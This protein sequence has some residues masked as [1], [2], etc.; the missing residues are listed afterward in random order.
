M[1]LTISPFCKEVY[2]SA[3]YIG[4][5]VDFLSSTSWLSNGH[6]D[7]LYDAECG[8][9]LKCF[10]I[11]TLIEH[12]LHIEP[13]GD[14]HPPGDMKN[15]SMHFSLKAPMGEAVER[16][17]QDFNNGL[18]NISILIASLCED[19]LLSPFIGDYFVENA[20]P[21]YQPILKFTHKLFSH[22]VCFFAAIS[23]EYILIH[24]YFA[25]QYGPVRGILKFGSRSF[26]VDCVPYRYRR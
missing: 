7:E 2:E 22:K 12:G 14:F 25:F 10:V 5:T 6:I 23:S 15:A 13:H 18:T 21:V 20:Q 8:A 19:S 17:K 1:A 26:D 16:Y 11:G 4:K 24:G 3:G 9:P